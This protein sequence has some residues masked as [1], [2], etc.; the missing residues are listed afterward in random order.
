VSCVFRVI[1]LDEKD[2]P[3]RGIVEK[4]EDTF[5]FGSRDLAYRAC[6]NPAADRVFI[7]AARQDIPRFVALVR[8]ALP[9]V[10]VAVKN[11]SFADTK[12]VMDAIAAFDKA[13]EGVVTR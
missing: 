8:A 2:E 13:A 10:E 6:D 1:A 4:H 5:R 9:L 3:A 12:R 7:A 11:P